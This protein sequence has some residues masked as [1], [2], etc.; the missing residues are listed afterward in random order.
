MITITILTTLVYL[1]A[2]ALLTVGFVQ[3]RRNLRISGI[4][5]SA[6]AVAGH[7]IV[8]WMALRVST[9]WDMN[10]FNTLSLSAWAVA[11]ALVLS[12]MRPGLLEAGI[13]VFPGAALCLALG[14]TIP[15]APL[16]LSDPSV[17]MELHVFSSLL[18]Y[19]LLSIAAFNALLLAV[20]DFLLRRPRSIRQL[21]MLPPLNVLEKL[22]FRLV[23][24]GWA[25]LTVSLVTGFLFVDDLL[26]QHLVHKTLLTLISWVLFGL[27]LVGRWWYGL[28]GRQAVFF[29]LI[30][31]FVLALGYF[32]SKLVLEILLDRSWSSPE[33]GRIA[34][35]RG[36][37][38]IHP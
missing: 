9:G 30:A 31:M 1:G 38:P 15:I 20:Q 18:A 25:V 3:A 29:T 24:A 6:L 5:L 14:Q 12:S 23:A 33:A 10:F 11:L 22:L 34:F 32:G 27:L 28:R 36:A 2:A 7:A 19:C 35:V 16:V 13:V 4:L 37:A 17:E 26:A 21:E 8:L